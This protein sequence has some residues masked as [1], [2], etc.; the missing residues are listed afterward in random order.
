MFKHKGGFPY[1][2]WS[3]QIKEEVNEVPAQEVII[4]AFNQ[5]VAQ[6]WAKTFSEQFQKGGF[7]GGA[8][9][10]G[11]SMEDAAKSTKSS[12]DAQKA[13][14]KALHEFIAATKKVAKGE[15][16][17][18][19]LTAK[20]LKSLAEL[21]KHTGD[22]GDTFTGM[23]NQVTTGTLT[24]KK[25]TEK[26]DEM[27]DAADDATKMQVRMGERVKKA[28]KSIANF[29]P[30]MLT[31]GAAFG[32]L[33]QASKDFSAQMRFGTDVTRGVFANMTDAIK[34]GVDPE[35]L[36][37]IQATNRMAVRTFSDMNEW[38]GQLRD[39]EKEMFRFVGDHTEATR[40]VAA[41]LTTL[42]MAGIRPTM[43]VFK[44]EGV[45]GQ[46]SLFKQFQELQAMTGQT[47]AESGEMLRGFTNDEAIRY[48]LTAAVDEEQRKAILRGVMARNAEFRALG[49]TK[50]QALSAASAL[51]QLA[52][53]SPRERM[54]QAAKL[55]ALAG[56]MGMSGMEGMELQKL[57]TM[58]RRRSLEPGAD[59]RYLEL[60]SKLREGVA[61]STVGPIQQ[62]MFASSMSKGLEAIVGPGSKLDISL[63]KG[64]EPLNKN[65][66]SM[67]Q[68]SSRMVELAVSS[69][70]LLQ[71]I[72]NAAQS[73]LVIGGFLAMRGL[74]T[75]GRLILG[76]M[77][78]GAGA[79]GP[80][81]SAKR[82]ARALGKGG[83]FG[84][85]AGGLRAGGGMALR[86]AGMAGMVI[87]AATMGHMAGEEFYKQ[88]DQGKLFG[89]ETSWAGNVQSGLMTMFGAIPDMLS[90]ERRKDREKITI[91]REKAQ[92]DV[93]GRTGFTN[94][95]TM[96][97]Y[98]D[99]MTKLREQDTELSRKLIEELKQLRQDNK[100]L[101]KDTI[102]AY[103]KN[104]REYAAANNGSDPV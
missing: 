103:L 62:E 74:L 89:I 43:K 6:Q 65:M 67:G 55:R 32:V 63:A 8:K 81:G 15:R 29:E 35:A 36:S 93:A 30:R 94:Y 26:L 104:R 61:E 90:T 47:F 66:E 22:V 92:E 86:G 54:K 18:T 75:T 12:T 88:L 71:K 83:R 9:A 4:A 84:R 51:E 96:Q 7:G 73:P 10:I 44:E 33:T 2:Y 34:L 69:V 20:Q 24:Y 57:H 14:I 79:L 46:K 87:S 37:E 40:L 95:E 39:A 80:G 56:A 50:E 52:G 59:A 77:R 1:K 21:K 64:L 58:G 70:S 3:H 48:R 23:A 5:T 16:Q 31:A 100:N 76:A 97:G 11:E 82:G 25:A 91:A 78:G 99:T 72:T 28:G 42:G 19:A 101:S 45:K 60:T 49:L 17:R 41:Q 68:S 85:I 27:S 98:L 38:A 13:S 102:D 53:I